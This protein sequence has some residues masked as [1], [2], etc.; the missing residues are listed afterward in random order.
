HTNEMID[1]V[2]VRLADG[3][4]V[5]ETALIDRI[6]LRRLLRVH[7][8]QKPPPNAS[9]VRGEV[10]DLVRLGLPA[11]ER[12]VHSS[13]L[14][15]LQTSGLRRV[16]AEL[17]HVVRLGV[18]RKLRVDGLINAV[19]LPDK[20]V[21]EPAPTIV[22]KAGLVH[23]VSSGTHRFGRSRCRCRPVEVK[24]NLFDVEPSF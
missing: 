3:P 5:A 24:R 13:P 10:S 7:G 17:K 9:K 8:L 12:D 2:P 16:E 11:A 15:T 23:D 4:E 20:E 19:A 14:A 1:G 18:P 6:G 22:D 21:R